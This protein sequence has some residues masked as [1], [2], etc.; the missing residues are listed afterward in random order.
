VLGWREC[1]RVQKVCVFWCIERVLGC[2]RCYRLQGACVKVERGH[3]RVER[4]YARV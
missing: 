3:M 2:R 4:V 1:V